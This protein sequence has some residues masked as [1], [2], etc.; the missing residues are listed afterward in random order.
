MLLWLSWTGG[1][2]LLL[3]LL[4]GGGGAE[5]AA[6]CPERCERARCP[7]VPADCAGGEALDACGCCLVC[8]AQ[9]GEPCGGPAGEPPC[10]EGLQC[11]LPPGGGVAAT[12]TV[13]KRAKAGLCVC[14]SSEPVCGSDARTY[15]NLCQLRAASRRS[16]R[17]QQPPVIAIQRGACGQGKSRRAPP[18]PPRQCG[19]GRGER[20]S[21]IPWGAKPG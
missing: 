10:G 14:T 7:A 1:C 16:E 18:Q 21:G 11:R 4:P 2:C 13:R 12:A 15:G 19:A 20:G 17:L 6:G 5:R 3:L 8:A 9:E